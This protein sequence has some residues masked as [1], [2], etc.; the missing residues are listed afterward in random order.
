MDKTK[1]DCKNINKR[2]ECE[3]T[4]FGVIFNCEDVIKCTAYEKDENYEEVD[5]IAHIF[6][7]LL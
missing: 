7:G 6:R 3:C 5:V 1:Y 2:G 4:C